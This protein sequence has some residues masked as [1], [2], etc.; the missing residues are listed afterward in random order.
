MVVGIGLKGEG[1]RLASLVGLVKSEVGDGGLEVEFGIGGVVG[2]ADANEF[3]GLLVV[4]ELIGVLDGF[5]TVPEE[6]GRP[7][8]G[9]RG[10]ESLLGG[11]VMAES[12][13]AGSEV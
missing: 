13:E 6:T 7:T 8:E 2:E 1:E 3:E 4:A 12:V 9:F 10:F 11:G 5:D